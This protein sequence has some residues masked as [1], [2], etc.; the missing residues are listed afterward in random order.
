[1]GIFLPESLWFRRSLVPLSGTVSPFVAFF[2]IFQYACFTAFWMPRELYVAP[3]TRS[4]SV[5]CPSTMRS[6]TTLARLK[7]VSSS[8]FF[9]NQ[10]RFDRLILQGHRHFDVSLETG[11]RSVINSVLIRKTS[12]GCRRV[13]IVLIIILAVVSVVCIA[14]ASSVCTGR[15]VH[16][17]LT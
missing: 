5:F 11:G 1:M 16:C 17:R 15:P 13:V 4:T 10:Y 2:V 9:Q 14:L 6:A 7:N 8:S 3:D 12:L